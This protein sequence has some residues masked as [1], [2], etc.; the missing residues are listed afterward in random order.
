MT[1]LQLDELI[2]QL[3]AMRERVGGDV[4]L[5]LGERGCELVM[6]VDT[7]LIPEDDVG[8]T[9]LVRVYGG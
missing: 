5:Q 6:G 9:T 4:L 2:E 7:L 3:T 8:I 1:A